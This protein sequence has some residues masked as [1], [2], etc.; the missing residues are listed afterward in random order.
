LVEYRTK[1]CVTRSSCT[2]TD[3]TDGI[4]NGYE[5]MNFALVSATVTAVE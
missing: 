5:L 2:A 3:H 4:G 1:C